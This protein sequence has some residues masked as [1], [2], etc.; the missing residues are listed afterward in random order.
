MRR[1]PGAASVKR[2]DDDPTPRTSD[3]HQ[4][5]HHVLRIIDELAEGHGNRH[6]EQA[7]WEGQTVCVGDQ[8]RRLDAPGCDAE[9]G[10]VEVQSDQRFGSFG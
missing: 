7:R 2:P 5:R 8:Q 4:F 9:H 10:G 3:A 6:V 1:A